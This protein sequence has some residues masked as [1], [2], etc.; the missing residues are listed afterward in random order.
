[1]EKI[2]TYGCDKLKEFFKK[3][4]IWYG[5]KNTHLIGKGYGG[6]LAGG[7]N[8]NYYVD[9][10]GL[11]QA[12]ERNLKYYHYVSIEYFIE[13]HT[14]RLNGEIGQSKEINNYEIF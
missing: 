1:M 6:W 4:G 14:K 12:T 3:I 9:E 11:F 10:K 13:Y 7:S 5:G 8:L 2:Y